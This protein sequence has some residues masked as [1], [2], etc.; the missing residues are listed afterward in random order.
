MTVRIVV[1]NKCLLFSAKAVV[2]LRAIK[3]TTKP[4][5][6]TEKRRGREKGGHVCLA[7]RIL[8]EVSH[9]MLGHLVPGAG[10]EPAAA[11]D[12]LLQH[13]WLPQ[14]E[15]GPAPAGL[16]EEPD[17]HRHGA[18]AAGGVPALGA[19]EISAA[20]ERGTLQYKIKNIN[21]LLP[22]TL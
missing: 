12:L 20:K 8:R 13:D 10:G 1:K 6:E 18:R 14:V 11:E 17:V 15:D 19:A 5:F 3:Q 4:Q 21:K 2:R 22:I 9:Q 16:V 7:S